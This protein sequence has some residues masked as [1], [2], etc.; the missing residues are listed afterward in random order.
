MKICVIAHKLF[1]NLQLRRLFQFF[2]R[3]QTV[4]HSSIIPKRSAHGKVNNAFL[5]KATTM[6]KFEAHSLYPKKLAKHFFFFYLGFGKQKI[7]I[8]L[9]GRYRSMDL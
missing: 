9:S 4:P 6:E 5:N 7:S 1:K 2:S 8:C 3:G